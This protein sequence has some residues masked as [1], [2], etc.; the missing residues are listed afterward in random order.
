MPFRQRVSIQAPTEVVSEKGH[1]GYTYLPLD[2]VESVP[3]TIFAITDER[4]EP[5][6]TVTEDR[7]HVYLAGHYPQITTEMVVNAGDAVY[8]IV[9]VAPTYRQR[10]TQLIARQV[11]V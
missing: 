6:M 4:Q 9:R 10:V 1:P 5:D 2:G 8:D 7:Y 11:A 3:A